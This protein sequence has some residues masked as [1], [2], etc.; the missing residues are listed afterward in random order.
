MAE[1]AAT[2]E[3]QE[4]YARSLKAMRAF[5]RVAL[6][7]YELDYEDN[8]VKEAWHD[9]R[10]AVGE[11]LATDP[12][13]EE[14]LIFNPLRSYEYRGGHV[15]AGHGQPLV[16]LVRDGLRSSEL[17]AQADPEMR[18]Q[19]VRDRADVAVAEIVD[20]LGVGE[21]Y[22][23]VSLD[24]KKA[25]ER[26]PSYWQ[27][28]GYREGM[29]VLQVYYRSS[30]GEVLAG[31]YSI[32]QSNKAALSRIFARYG[33]HIPLDET[34]NQWIRHGIRLR[35]DREE[36]E[37]FGKGIVRAHRAEIGAGGD[38]LSVT[39]LIAANEHLV[40][41]CFEGY[42]RPL[43]GS[44]ESGSVHPAIQDLAMKLMNN[45]AAYV[46]ADRQSLMRLA[47]GGRAYEQDVRFMEG[48]IRYG[49]VEELRKLIPHYLRQ[50][51]NHGQD[52]AIARDR[53]FVSVY[54]IEQAAYIQQMAHVM[55]GNV[56]SG[57]TANRSYGG[58]TPAGDSSGESGQPGG[59]LGA[60]QQNV[61]GGKDKKQGSDKDCEFISKSCPKCGEKNVKTKVTKTH[62]SG[63]CG[64]RVTKK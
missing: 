3:S 56:A 12:E 15:L 57:M 19:V 24:P 2:I 33:V 44:L 6:A 54:R 10:T 51:V 18:I 28:R 47:N 55:A 20:G 22:T 7:G 43:A 46:P 37:E 34:D 23:V 8:R 48:K 35:T 61:F 38:A 17:A 32:K 36:A 49:L 30:S 64:C 29:A 42:L 31:A 59:E 25:L 26:N 1:A 21:L 11:N 39:E 9:F 50:A 27:G 62:I 13:F 63:S 45:R 5:G 4:V 16:E 14:Q 40:K 58:C 53:G 41:A 52:K 60:D